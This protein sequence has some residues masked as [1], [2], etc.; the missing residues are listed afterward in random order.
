MFAYLKLRI[1]DRESRPRVLIVSRG[2]WDESKGTSSTL[3]N[4]FEDYDSDKLAHIYIESFT[5]NTRCCK[6]FFQISEASLIHRIYNKRIQ[7]GH[8]IDANTGA[9][10]HVNEN[11]QKEEERVM[12][13]V[14]RHRS[15]VFSWARELLWAFNGWKNDELKRFILSFNPDVVWLDGSPLPLMNRLS[16]FVLK[17]ANKPAV[18]F[19]QDDIY[20]KKSQQGGFLRVL[21]RRYLRRTVD[22]VVALCSGMFVASPKMKQEYDELFGMD[23]VFIAKSFQLP[24]KM[25]APQIHQPIR[26][27]YLGQ[28]IY[29]RIKTLISVANTVGIINK[30]KDLVQLSIYTNNP[31][32]DKQRALLL[33]NKNVF[34]KDAVPY[35]E[36]PRVIAENDVLVFVETFDP[37]QNRLARLSFSTKI[38]DYLRSGKCVFAVGPSDIAPIEYFV[39]EDAALVATDEESILR[40]MKQV[41][42]P[43]VVRDYAEKASACVR[44]NH[45]RNK[46]NEIVYDK[47]TK[48]AFA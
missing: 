15:I 8:I 41:V 7:T 22:R 1:M 6:Q 23:S 47:L 31:I 12:G 11:V 45:D 30:E 21:Y 29:G 38:S 42:D 39:D 9:A 43:A 46:M 4:I 26:M 20:T 3:T 2:V 16:E 10:N 24:E 25:T 27:V 13:F 48:I 36:V 14:R 32:G 17:T 33:K 28:I 44:K 37:K 5:P 35:S 34:I 19:M 18:I 40:C